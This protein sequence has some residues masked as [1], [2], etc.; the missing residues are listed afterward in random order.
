MIAKIIT[1]GEDRE[2]AIAKMKRALHEL[3]V[4]GVDTNREFQQAI[5]NDDNFVYGNFDT[6]YLQ[7]TFLP[8]WQP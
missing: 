5:L 4:E 2:E 3:V 7:T 1:K 8:N 6:D